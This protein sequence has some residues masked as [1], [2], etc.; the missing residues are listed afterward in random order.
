MLT[1]ILSSRITKKTHN[2]KTTTTKKYYLGW[3]KF[4][5]LE[6]KSQREREILLSAGL[7]HKWPQQ[8][9]QGRAKARSLEFHLGLLRECKGPNTWAISHCLPR[10]INRELGQKW[11]NQTGAHMG[12]RHYSLWVNSLCLSVGTWLIYS[13]SLILFGLSCQYIHWATLISLFTT[14]HISTSDSQ[15]F[16]VLISVNRQCVVHSHC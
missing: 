15:K 13:W 11:K 2:S 3:Q 5:L 4:Y 9:W 10:C 8:P 14:L 6:R 7:L 16:H 1:V 12:C